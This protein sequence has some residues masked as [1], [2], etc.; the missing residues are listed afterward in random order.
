MEARPRL[1]KSNAEGND[2]SEE[3]DNPKED[4]TTKDIHEDKNNVGDEKEVLVGH[5]PIE[6]SKLINQFLKADDSNSMTATVAGKRKPDQGLVVPSI[7]KYF[8]LNK[9]YSEILYEELMKKKIKYSYLELDMEEF[10]NK[11]YRIQIKNTLVFFIFPFIFL[12]YF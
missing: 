10:I 11:K 5:I 8:S 4:Q 7:F 9:K 1:E 3:N 2:G 6:L 12:P